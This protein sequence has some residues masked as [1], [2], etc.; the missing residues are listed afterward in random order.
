MT[1][2]RLKLSYCSP[3]PLSIHFTPVEK[4]GASV[5]ETCSTDPWVLNVS[6]FN[7]EWIQLLNTCSQ[8]IIVHVTQCTLIEIII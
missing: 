2:E 1:Q 6:F 8:T 7:C 5:R 4:A 3:G